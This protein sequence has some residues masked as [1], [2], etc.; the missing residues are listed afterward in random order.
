[1]KTDVSATPGR[2]VRYD[3]AAV[4]DARPVQ[5]VSVPVG[6]ILLR[7][8]A[9]EPEVLAVGT[10]DEVDAHPASRIAEKVSLPDLVVIPALVNAHTHLDLTLVGPRSHEPDAGFLGFIETVRAHR[11]V[12]PVEIAAAVTRGVKLALA[13]GTAAVGDIAGAVRG[14]PCLTAWEALAGS[15]LAGVSF[16]EFF[17]FGRGDE[18]A[19]RVL[20]RLVRGLS[21]AAGRI[22]LGIQPHAPYTV[23]SGAY[24]WS[25]DLARSLSIPFC[26]HLGESPDERRFIRDGDGPLQELLE[27]VGVWDDTVRGV[28]GRGRSPVAH[29]AEALGSTGDEAWV[30]VHVNDADDA[31]IDALTRARAAVVYCPRASAYFGFDR[32]F[33]PHRYRD[34]LDAGLRV[35]LGTDSIISLPPA[36]ADPASGGMSVLDEMRLL[37]RRDGTDARTLLAMGTTVGASLL[38]LDPDRF[39]LRAGMT[40]AGVLALSVSDTDPTLPPLE[41]VMRSGSPPRWLAG[42]GASP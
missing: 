25:R 9:G 26:T 32:D 33:G 37:S 39:L 17:A 21:P 13:G 40:P 31:D 15:P 3:A 20:E 24:R 5:R 8:G 36:A 29:V 14:S 12:D 38:G 6:S 18:P 34:M 11:P 23:S 1:M 35:A 42:P 41:R 19:R 4:E 10:R 27:R 28:I 2:I 22:R 16:L 30:A 7:S